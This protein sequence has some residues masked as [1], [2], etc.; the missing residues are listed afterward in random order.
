[1]TGPQY[2]AHRRRLAV[3]FVLQVICAAG[4][5]YVWDDLDTLEKV[6]A[7]VLAVIVVPSL[8]SVK[9]LFVSY[10]SYRRESA[11]SR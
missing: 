11:K 6:V 3:V 2:A 10:E 4:L 8:T 7:V 1:M 5:I 9:K